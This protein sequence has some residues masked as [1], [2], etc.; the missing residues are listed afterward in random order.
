MHRFRCYKLAVQ[1]YQV[2]KS[3]RLK[4]PLKNQLERAASSIALNLC[5]GWGRGIS[6]DRKRF[7][8]IALGSIRE[9][10]AIVAL[11]PEAFTL[12]QA[13]LLNQLA[14]ST[15]RLVLNAPTSYP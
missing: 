10:E 12:Q 14:A 3:R 1:F 4:G 13:G 6:K 9:C 11:E 7:W 15:Y 8:R 2:A 5:E